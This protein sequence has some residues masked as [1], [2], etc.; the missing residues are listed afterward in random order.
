MYRLHWYNETGINHAQYIGSYSGACI[1]ALQP[2][3]SPATI[4]WAIWIFVH[5]DPLVDSF[6]F[7]HCQQLMHLR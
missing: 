5:M 4:P 3:E 7:L 6:G 2:L 1:Y